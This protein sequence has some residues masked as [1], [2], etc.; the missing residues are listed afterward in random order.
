MARVSV[1]V[2]SFESSHVL[3]RCLTAL[4]HATT[5][6]DLEVWVVDNASTDGS[7]DLAARVI[8]DSQVVRLPDNRGFAAGVNAGLARATGA[9]VAVINPDAV[10][11]PGAFDTLMDVL[12]STPSAG[13][14]APLV[15]HPSGAEEASVG[16]FPTAVRER[17]HALWLDRAFGLDGR[18]RAFPDATDT[19]DW[20]SGCAWLLRA[21]TARAV[22]PLD[23]R[24]FMYFDDV[25]YCRR[26][27]NAGWTVVA[28]RRAR[29]LHEAG[30]G[31]TRTSA[32]AAEG[33]LSGAT[34]FE[35]HLGAREAAVARRWLLRGWRLR[36]LAHQAAGWLGRPTGAQRAARYRRSLELARSAS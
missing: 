31:S 24:F 15:V 9:A 34:Y 12:A 2:V 11:A 16:H 35:K 36:A 13:L 27:W 8:P 19:V 17:N 4:P 14:V 28:T 30:H 1:V 6:H 20:A 7:A 25:D 32:L 3:E 10:V 21:D 26:V 5:K 22:G 33:G 18:T 23:E 29:V